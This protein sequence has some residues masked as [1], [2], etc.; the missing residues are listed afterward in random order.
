M[1]INWVEIN[2]Y[3]G[4]NVNKMKGLKY[5][6]LNSDYKTNWFNRK[7]LKD[8][9]SIYNSR[10]VEKKVFVPDKTL[11]YLI[12]FRKNLRLIYKGKL[13]DHWILLYRNRNLE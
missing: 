2:F 11:S 13:W 9:I 3:E 7:Q 4:Y 8:A 10:K 6:I 5:I 1:K 12:N